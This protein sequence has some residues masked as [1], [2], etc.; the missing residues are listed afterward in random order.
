MATKGHSLSFPVGISH[1]PAVF[2]QQHVW[3]C[4]QQKKK[5]F[6]TKT[7]IYPLKTS[8]VKIVANKEI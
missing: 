8:S 6:P 3:E 1:A 2:P 4:F 7:L 5:T